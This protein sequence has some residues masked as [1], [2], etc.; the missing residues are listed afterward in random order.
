MAEKK[1][2]GRPSSYTEAKALIICER[3][4]LGE[5]LRT[6]CLDDDMPSQPTVF[7]WLRSNESFLKHYAHAREAQAD[8]Y[9]ES[10]IDISDEKETTT[11]GGNE[12]GEEVEIVFDS[13]AVARNRLRVDA[14]KWYASKLAPKKYSDKVIYAGD[15]EN[16]LVTQLVVSSTDIMNKIKGG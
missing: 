7:L 2:Q 4:A 8:Y 5:S 10:I 3:L 1:K 14:R 9:A 11:R 12:D 16:P 6:I 13:T 15:A